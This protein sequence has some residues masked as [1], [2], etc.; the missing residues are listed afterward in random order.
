MGGLFPKDPWE[1]GFWWQEAAGKSYWS[2][3]PTLFSFLG[4]WGAGLGFRAVVGSSPEYPRESLCI[5]APWQE[6]I[7]CSC[8]IGKEG[9]IGKNWGKVTLKWRPVPPACSW[10]NSWCHP[11]DPDILNPHHFFLYGGIVFPA[12]DRISSSAPSPSLEL[13]FLQCCTIPAS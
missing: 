12:K 6:G 2:F 1:E 5:S 10:T 9:K 7:S 13:R 8:G 4:S 11:P 3:I